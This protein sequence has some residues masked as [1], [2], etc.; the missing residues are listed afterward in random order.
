MRDSRED[1]LKS[2]LGRLESGSARSLPPL[3]GEDVF[4]SESLCSGST[5]VASLPLSPFKVPFCVWCGIERRGCSPRLAPRDKWRWSRIF[6]VVFITPSSPSPSSPSHTRSLGHTRAP[7]PSL[8]LKSAGIFAPIKWIMAISLP[9]QTGRW[10]R[11]CS[12]LPTPQTD[13]TLF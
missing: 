12:R 3:A 6:R 1:A 13:L 9:R 10:A 4:Q 11:A 8:L 7:I 2:C 5:A